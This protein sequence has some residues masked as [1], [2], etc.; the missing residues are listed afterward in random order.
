M[1]T[2]LVH[3]TLP[4]ELQ[5]HREALHDFSKTAQHIPHHHSRIAG[6]DGTEE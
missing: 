6:P 1:P 2:T 5:A 3:S 4:T